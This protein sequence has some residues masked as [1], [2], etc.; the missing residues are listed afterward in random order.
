MIRKILFAIFLALTI[1]V[2]KGKETDTIVVYLKNDLNGYRPVTNPDS[3][4][5]F[6]MVLPPDS[7]D[8]KYNIKEYYRNG[9]VKLIGKSE[10][11]LDKFKFGLI[12]LSG[13]C[14]RYYPNGN[15]ES[16]THYTKD[17]KDGNE[18]LFYPTGRIYSCVKYFYDRTR[19]SV[20]SL[21]WECHDANGE[22]ICSEGN[23]DWILYDEKFE[24]ILVK[25]KVKH[26]NMDG[27]WI[28]KIANDDS[29]KYVYKY[30]RGD[31]IS[32]VGYDKGGI[33][34][35]FIL[36]TVAANYGGNFP[37]FIDW[38][39]SR[40]KM[41]KDDNGKK[42]PLDNVKISFIVEKDGSIL[43][44]ETLGVVNND[45]T[46]AITKVLSKCTGWTP[47]KL[48][49]I[50]YKTRVTL[51]LKYLTTYSGKWEYTNVPFKEE[52]LKF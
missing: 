28:G 33:A 1:R 47:T 32:S 8:D 22:M 7:A 23:G 18:Y 10:P 36:S 45:L 12:S 16:I 30:D 19:G 5:F 41:P 35:P 39:N 14:L 21:N 3:A 26:G 40:L 9:K 43:Y 2:A 27:E 48:Y 50:P 13:D 38:L 51:P 24:N 29:I 11:L 44:V 52:I 15:K 31:L 20:R 49:G 34:Y 4:D 17:N 46:Q 42:I 25:G 6:R 37:A